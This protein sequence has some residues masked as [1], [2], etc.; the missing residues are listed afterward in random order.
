MVSFNLF[1][2]AYISSDLLLLKY[3]VDDIVYLHEKAWIFDS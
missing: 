3:F 2:N 1:P